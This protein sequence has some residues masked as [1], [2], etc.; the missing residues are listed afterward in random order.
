MFAKD[1]FF[2][3]ESCAGFRSVGLERITA[4][5]SPNASDAEVGRA[6]LEALSQYRV[7]L[8]SEIAEFHDLMRIEARHKEWERQLL[9]QAGY[10][11]RQQLYSGL[12]Y[13][14]V[15]LSNSE[16]SVSATAKDRH[17][18]FQGNG[19]T[20]VVNVDLGLVAIG[21][22]VKKAVSECA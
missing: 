10:K 7:L 15:R 12:K 19:F 18:G 3:V 20:S 1:S 13:V 14:P 17:H 4:F 11:T 22:A 5:L 2:C 6:V 16:L 9:V 21:A 8:Q